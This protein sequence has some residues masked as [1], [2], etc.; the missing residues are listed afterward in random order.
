MVGWALA[1]VQEDEA[2][3]EHRSHLYLPGYK[4]LFRGGDAVGEEEQD[5]DKK[6]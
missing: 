6:H 3:N 1:P 2:D 4:H 5:L